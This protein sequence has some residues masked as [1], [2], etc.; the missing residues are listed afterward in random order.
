MTD[1]RPTHL[2]LFSGIGG[3]ALAAEWAGFRTIGFSEIDP[4]S[5]AVLAKRFQGPNYGD[6]RGVWAQGLGRVDLLTAG[7]PCQPTSFAGKQKGEAD[8]RWLWPA[9][10][11]V[12]RD[13]GPTYAVFENPTAIITLH[14]GRAFN[15]IISGFYTL[16]YS[17]WWEPLPACA[18][19]APHRRDR[20]FIV[21][22]SERCER[23]HQS[24]NGTTRRMGREFQPFPWDRPWESALCEFRG[25]DDGLSY[26]VDRVDCIRNSIVPQVAYPIL[27]AIYDQITCQSTPLRHK[28]TSPYSSFQH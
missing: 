20:L 7:V 17:V 2:D 21:A 24:Y 16:G 14:G 1:E 18:A 6:V 22:Y 11:R 26:G 5:S 3:F 19:G 12:L 4:Y 10:L 23:G 25:M 8:P 13:V 28:E 15:R 27:K 9:A